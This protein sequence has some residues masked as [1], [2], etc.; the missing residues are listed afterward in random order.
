MADETQA[1]GAVTWDVDERG[2]ATVRLNRPERN[3][4]YDGTLIQGLHDALDALGTMPGLRAVAVSGNGRHFQAGADL[5]WLA[6]VRSADAA[7]NHRVSKATADAVDR[8]NRA[9][10]PTFA[11]IRGACVGGGT[12]LIAACDVVVATE[13]AKFAISEVRWGLTAAII[14]PQLVDAIGVR[15][16]RR[17]ALTGEMFSAQDAQRIGL[18]H[19]VVPDDQLEDRVAELISKTLENA[20]VAIAETKAQI[21]AEGRGLASPDHF[22]SLIASHAK[23]RQ[24]DEASEGLASFHEK[25]S[26]RW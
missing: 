5:K 12:G 2:V 25:R 8:L 4:A 23:K 7:E 19:D 9:P 24:S 14:V 22:E 21:L 6:E 18:V 17:Y 10:V 16:L 26:A 20:P 1:P 3:N 11:A 15:Q 13:T